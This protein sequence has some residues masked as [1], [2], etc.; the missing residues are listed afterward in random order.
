MEC[1]TNPSY[2]PDIQC[3]INP[4]DNPNLQCDTNPSY[5]SNIQ[6]DTNPSCNLGTQDPNSGFDF[7]SDVANS[8]NKEG[9]EDNLYDS[10]K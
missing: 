5:N 1:D 8:T 4:S 10:I 6:C 9:R 3:G 2:N 7:I